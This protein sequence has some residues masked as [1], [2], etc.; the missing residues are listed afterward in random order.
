MDINGV[1]PTDFIKKRLE[2]I[3]II[4]VD[5]NREEGKNKSGKK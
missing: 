1:R 4:D 2:D 5:D 3:A